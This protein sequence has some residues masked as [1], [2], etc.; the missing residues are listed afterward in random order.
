MKKLGLILVSVLVPVMFSANLL[1]DDNVTAKQ[2]DITLAASDA[3]ANMHWDLPEQASE[4]RE[5]RA[6]QDLEYRAQ[7]LNDKI[8]AQLDAKLEEKLSRQ[9]NSGF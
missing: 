8:D 4:Q 2:P 5:P 1:A 6:L 7:V 9:L 3:G